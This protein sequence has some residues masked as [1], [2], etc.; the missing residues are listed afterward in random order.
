MTDNRI[1]IVRPQDLT[2]EDAS[3]WAGF[4]AQR[5]DQIGPYFDM[6]YIQ[7]IAS[8]VPGSAVARFYHKDKV[9]GYFPY[10]VRAGAL[11]PMGAPLSDYHGLISEAGLSVDFHQLLKVTKARRLDFQGWIGEMDAQAKGLVLQRRVAET[12][13][14]F[15]S[16]YDEQNQQHHKFFKNVAR[17]E[18]NV[19]KDFGGFDYSW[20]RVTPTIL[21]W[22]IAHKREQYSR[23]GLHDIFSCGWTHDLLNT[24]SQYEDDTYGLRAGVFRHEGKIVAAE[25]S[26]MDKES[27]HLW[28]PAYDPAYYRYTV[29]ILLTMAIIRDLADKGIQRFDFGTGGEDYKSPMTVAAGTCLEGNLQYAPRIAERSLDMITALI[30]VGRPKFERARMSLRRRVH[31]IRA[32]EIS[33]SGWGRALILLA[34][35]GFM[36]LKPARA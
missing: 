7:A 10:Q 26:L 19:L 4:V 27:V 31:T 13:D 34:Q 35:R 20:E 30:P 15:Q 21:N 17:C 14:G 24:L 22:V 12:P 11:Q 9:V 1:D 6:R 33:L 18:R 32:T 23:C 8:A 29:G 28:F 3:L 25:I 16:W 2:A 36:R 5:S